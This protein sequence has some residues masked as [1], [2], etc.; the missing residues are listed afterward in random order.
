M[1]KAIFYYRLAAEQNIAFAHYKLAWLYLD[2]HYV[3]QDPVEGLAGL[4]RA[5]RL[6]FIQAQLDLS[7]LYETGFAETPQDLIQA[8]K[9]LSIASSLSD[10]DLKPKQENLEA[11]MS[12]IQLAQAK[13]T[14]GICILTGYQDC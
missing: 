13:I 5:A 9:W 7:H 8:Y 4:Q 1:E 12:F 10:E 14:S 3:E 2:G 11:K 6:G